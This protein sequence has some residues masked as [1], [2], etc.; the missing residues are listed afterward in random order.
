MVTYGDPGFCCRVA[1]MATSQEDV[2][3]PFSLQHPEDWLGQ[4]L[5]KAPIMPLK[6]R[7]RCASGFNDPAFW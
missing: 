1:F 3:A 7:Y 4:S 6:G 5:T 2:P